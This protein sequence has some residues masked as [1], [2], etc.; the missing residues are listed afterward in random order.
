[1]V[2]LDGLRSISVI[3]KECGLCPLHAI[4]TQIA[5]DSAGKY[6]FDAPQ[7]PGL[8]HTL[9]GSH[10]WQGLVMLLPILVVHQFMLLL[11]GFHA[12]EVP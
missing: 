10:C 7:D 9:V 3:Y 8:I 5:A 6:L 1:M 11:R 4:Q 12:V 2:S